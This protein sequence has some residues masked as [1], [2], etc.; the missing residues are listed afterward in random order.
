MYLSLVAL[1]LPGCWTVLCGLWSFAQRN[2]SPFHSCQ[3]P[4]VAHSPLGSAELQELISSPVSHDC[5]RMGWVPVR[6]SLWT[7]LGQSPSCSEPAGPKEKLPGS[8]QSYSDTLATVAGSAPLCCPFPNISVPS[9]TNID[10]LVCEIQPMKPWKLLLQYGKW[11]RPQVQLTSI[12]PELAAGNSRR[13]FLSQESQPSTT[14]W[15]AGSHV[16]L[17]NRV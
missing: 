1:Q 11:W 9:V 12:Y 13:Q 14:C 8:F 16:C 7:V 10:H 15:L 6:C 17:K 4:T 3:S 5:V 2:F